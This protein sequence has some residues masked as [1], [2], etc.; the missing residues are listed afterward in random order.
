MI[1]TRRYDCAVWRGTTNALS[2]SDRL[3]Y[4]CLQSRPIARSD[5]YL[6]AK[7][8]D[9]HHRNMFSPLLVAVLQSFVVFPSSLSLFP[10]FKQEVRN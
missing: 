4:V 2:P 9:W 5:E 7:R 1:T 3:V 6:R 10:F 8:M